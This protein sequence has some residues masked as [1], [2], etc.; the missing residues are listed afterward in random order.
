MGSASPRSAY[1]QNVQAAK[2]G[3]SQPR[4]D[5]EYLSSGS[6]PELKQHGGSR[7]APPQVWTKRSR[8]CVCTCQSHVELVTFAVLTHLLHGHRLLV[9]KRPRANARQRRRRRCRRHTACGLYHYSVVLQVV[10]RVAL[11]PAP[12]ELRLPGNPLRFLKDV[13]CQRALRVVC[14]S[15]EKWLTVSTEH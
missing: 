15:K 9:A 1:T 6:K 3:E 4:L 5:G 11:H 8:A 2:G 14:S 7:H 12:P 10:H 13:R